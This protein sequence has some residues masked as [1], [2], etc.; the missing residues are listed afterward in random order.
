MK[1]TGAHGD[2]LL[3][4]TEGPAVLNFPLKIPG[5]LEMLPD[6]KDLECNSA[7]KMTG[8]LK[9]WLRLLLKAMETGVSGTCAQKINTLPP[10]SSSM[11]IG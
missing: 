2:Q 8:I 1:E 5:L 9:R 11:K 3:R 6:G 10:L 4:P 7:K